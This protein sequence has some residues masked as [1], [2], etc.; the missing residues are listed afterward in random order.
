M[1]G[2]KESTATS[3]SNAA[4]NPVN[5]ATTGFRRH[6]KPEDNCVVPGA[7]VPGA[8]IDREQNWLLRS[9]STERCRYD[10]VGGSWHEVLARRLFFQYHA[11]V[12]CLVG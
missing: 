5:P 6:Q 7:M 2:N 10:D 9:L 4:D 11:S 1:L 12:T 3:T 8:M